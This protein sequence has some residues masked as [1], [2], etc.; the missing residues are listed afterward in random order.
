MAIPILHF[1][2]KYFVNPDEGLGSTYERFIINRAL[3]K[4]VKHFAINTVL[5]A[6]S[7]GFTGMSGINSLG[8]AQKGIQ[9]SLLDH[10]ENR[11]VKI[12]ELWNQYNLPIDIHYSKDY[13]SLE[14]DNKVFDMSWNFSALW[15]VDDLEL[16]LT[17]LDMINKN[18]IL[19][20]VPN[21]TGLGYMQ[22]KYF[23][24]DDLNKYLKEENI[25]IYTIKKILID[26]HWKLLHHELI[27]CPLWPDIGMSKED[28]VH[29]LGLHNI[30]KFKNKDHEINEPKTILDYYLG[31]KPT[32]PHDFTKYEFFEKYAPLWFKKI[33]AHHQFMLFIR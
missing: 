23:G 29:K 19:I 2:Q 25:N 14:F 21:Q 8:L 31:K 18:V 5:E 27:D 10:D 33:W 26:K 22:Q 1:W 4:I 3:F 7:F 13:S 12:K 17:E 20:M 11:I 28:F 6:P 24:Q 16:F 15:F 32:M 30:I 9:V